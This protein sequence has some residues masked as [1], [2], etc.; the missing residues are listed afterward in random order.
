MNK[1]NLY[2]YYFPNWHV[3]ARNDVW[4]GKGWT[5]WEVTKCARP[6]FEGHYQPRVPLWGYEDEADPEVMAKKIAC[7]KKYGIKGFIF[8]TY[9]YDDGPYR[10]RC[11]DE[12]FLKAKGNEDF[13]FS[14]MW[15]N[16][17][18]IYAHPSPRLIVSPVLKSGAVDLAAFVRI[19]DDFIEKYFT[20]P[21]YTRINGKIMFTI[22]NLGKLIK[23]LGGV[24]EA[25]EALDGLRQRVRNR[26]LGEMHLCTVPA[27]IEDDIEDKRKIN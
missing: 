26:G 5:E 23:E 8:D 2:A 9:Y 10:A 13:E 21:N 11:L 14:V 24:K 20:K 27:I 16:H 7:A 22:Y 25:K 1:V 6:R 19:T 17:D 12:G 3:D 18:A 15:C 4:H